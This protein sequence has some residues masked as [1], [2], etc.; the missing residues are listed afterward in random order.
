MPLLQSML[1]ATNGG[2]AHVHVGEAAEGI[3]RCVEHG[4]V[5]ESYILIDG[6]MQHRDMLEF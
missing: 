3:V 1:F 5:G 4:Q 2:R 6:V